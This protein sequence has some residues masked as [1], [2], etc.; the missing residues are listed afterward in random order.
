MTG[1][2]SQLNGSTE[3]RQFIEG[4]QRDSAAKIKA[5]NHGLLLL[6]SESDELAA[7]LKRFTGD[8]NAVT[9]KLLD[10]LARVELRERRPVGPKAEA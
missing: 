10:T 3:I 7:A 4:M 5:L 1:R 6:G 9:A 2:K 8:F